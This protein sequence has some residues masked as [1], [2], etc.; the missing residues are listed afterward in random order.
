[1]GH[2]SCVGSAMP[3]L[4]ISRNMHHIA[5]P[6]TLGWLA[7]GADEAS[8]QCHRQDLAPFVVVPE[9]AGARREADVVGHAV[10]GL[11]DGILGFGQMGNVAIGIDQ[12]YHV[13]SA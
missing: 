8:P 13:H 4:L 7:F 3:V 6:Q 11:E 1:M 12:R 9:G 5:D 10:V 2:A